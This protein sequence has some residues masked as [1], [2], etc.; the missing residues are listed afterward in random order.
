MR[1][2]TLMAKAIRRSLIA[3]AATSF[4]MSGVVFAN[5]TT[6]NG[7]EEVERIE[8]TGS[9]IKRTDMETSAPIHVMDAEQ[10]KMSGFTNVEDILNQL[11]QLETASNA[12]QSNGASGTAS[13]DLRGLGSNRTLVLI[14]GR[15]MQAGSITSQT[16][17]INQ[18]PA[19][20]IR[21]VEVMTG[22]AA[23]VYGADAVAGVVNFIMDSDFDG[24]SI[25]VGA[26]GYQH[27]NDNSYIQ[28]LMD[29]KGFE[30]PSGST[31]VDGKAYNID[32]A[33][34]SDFADG[35]GHAVAYAVWRRND[36]LLQGERDYSSCALNGSQSA[37]GG[38]A[39][40]PLAHFDIYP[41]VNGKV[42]Y[43]QNFW[44]YTDPDGNGFKPDDG[45][46]YNYAPVNHFMR[47]NERISLG[48]FLNYEISDHAR[49]Y[50]EL[51]FMQ[52]RTA[53]QIAESGTF[54]NEEYLMDYNNPLLT[55]LQKQQLQSQFNQTDVDQ[56]VAYIGKRNV[57]GGPRSNNLEHNS[58]R[59]LTGMEGDINDNWTYDVS[60]NYSATSSS[61]VYQ[62]D[63]LAPKIA[64][65][66]GAI[67]TECVEA[68]GC[69]YYNV[70]EPDG[71]TAEQAAQL[72]GVGVQTGLVTQT[73]YSGYVTGDI[74]VT[75]PSA[76]DP[77]AM[78]FGFERREQD[79]E[80]ISDTVYEEG[81]LLGQGGP[82]TSLYGEIDVNELYTE[83]QIP[84]LDN[85][86]F[87]LGARY[88]DYSSSGGNWTY[89]VGADYTLADAYMFRA[90]FNRAVRAPN[91]SELF[92][93]QNIGLWS[94]ADGCA[95][96]ED[97]NITFSEAQCANTGVTI[98]Q[99][100][101]IGSSPAGQYNEFAGG[102]PD[103]EPEEAETITLGLV[104]NPLD[105]FSFSLDYYNIE[106]ESVISTVGAERILNI[107][108]ET[109][110]SAFCQ[111]VQR[112]ASGSLWLGKSGYVVNLSDNI[113]G[114]SW[115]GID[116]AA[117]YN[118]EL[119]SGDLSFDI[120]GSYA[121]KKEIQ[122]IKGDDD[123]AYDC[124][125][126]ISSDC[127]ATPD[128]RHTLT[129]KYT[130]SDWVLAAKWRYFGAI[131]YDGTADARLSEQGGIDA[132]NYF[133]LNGT[134]VLT[135]YM[136]VTAGMNNL[137]DKEP[138]MVGNSISTNANTIAGFY[139]T[140]GRFM[141]VSVNLKF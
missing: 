53:G 125:G 44:G 30:Y 87:D 90:S 57:E 58:Y 7:A 2:Q 16:A 111:N 95:T 64:P 17:D 136:S 84:V 62:N 88:S 21:R 20:L 133:D 98:D 134:Y 139:D 10:I 69:L 40:T 72:A 1:T 29:E 43:A 127:F 108:A 132:Y 52:N 36:E 74:G 55:D 97:G 65:R 50:V 82:I 27:K 102:N 138:P 12:F 126:T 129:A 110:D 135:D 31:G 99:Y 93:A 119:G 92:N 104:A 45:Y 123:L 85:L 118:I 128:W 33:I 94:G 116:A 18:I 19:A 140:L 78:V 22:G 107:C 35:K 8:V 130:A 109:G 38:S 124:A 14:N 91:V 42:D 115:E 114:R 37:C 56:F 79:Y 100:G 113:G 83:L 137:F 28:G 4:A 13:L 5:E 25:N 51:S 41:V 68:D 6:G 106:M 24:I 71:V 120:I 76:S 63:L 54:F 67:D 23:A 48:S 105:N 34:G 70:F 112:S 61:S 32:L 59:I 9:R 77:I 47:P 103:L 141:H 81:Q 49:P 86:G 11:P 3:T 101:N 122:P 80:R 131:D 73:I 89:K 66:V 96:D 117:Q 26:S 46:R 121:M 60:F 39:N 75:I 15:R